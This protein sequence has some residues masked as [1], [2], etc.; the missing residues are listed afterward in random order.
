MCEEK[1]IWLIYENRSISEYF[2]WTVNTMT[3]FLFFCPTTR[4]HLK[5]NYKIEWRK[6]EQSVY[7]HWNWRPFLLDSTGINFHYAFSLL[8][9]HICLVSLQ[10][11]LC[12]NICLSMPNFQW[13][14]SSTVGRFKGYF[15][16]CQALLIQKYG[17]ITAIH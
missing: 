14:C 3:M 6:L 11:I 10:A 12:S 4:R 5:N 13:N 17:R 7:I 1:F 8:H 2:M 9:C 16:S 15:I